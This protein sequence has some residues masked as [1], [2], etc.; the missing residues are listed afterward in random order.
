MTSTHI[1]SR[2]ET[3]SRASSAATHVPPPA[4][5]CPTVPA[6]QGCVGDD[7]PGAAAIT[8]RVQDAQTQEPPMTASSPTAAALLVLEVPGR[9]ARDLPRAP[10]LGVDVVRVLGRALERE[11]PAASPVAL[12]DG[13]RYA[14]VLHRVDRPTAMRIAGRALAALEEATGRQGAGAAA[15]VLFGSGQPA[16]ADLV[17]AAGRAALG[18]PAVTPGEAVRCVTV[19]GRL[20]EPAQASGNDV[21]D[22]LALLARPVC[23][24]CGAEGQQ[25]ELLLRR[26]ADDGQLVPAVAVLEGPARVAAVAWAADQA[27]ALLAARWGAGRPVRLALELPQETAVA[28][29]VLARIEAGPAGARWPAHALTIVVRPADVAGGAGVAAVR[30]LA[31]LGVLVALDVGRRADLVAPTDLPIARVM[32]DAA[33]LVALDDDADRRVRALRRAGVRVTATGVA[34]RRLLAPLRAIGVDACQGPVFGPALPI[35]ACVLGD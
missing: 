16:G 33:R 32:V 13:P 18:R 35:D 12:L 9:P 20:E 17:L 10:S 21:T 6:T 27:I 14:A 4:M 34:D 19:R 28:S 11:H 29:A 15:V 5:V 26:R 7:G 30:R 24:V 8:R 2:P 25:H 23:G 31:D 1:V 22:R 3:G